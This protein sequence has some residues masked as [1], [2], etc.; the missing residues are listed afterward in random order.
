ML[1]AAGLL[2]EAV[3]SQDGKT[4]FVEYKLG[5]RTAAQNP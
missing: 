2:R 5:S 4:W 1:V 3:F